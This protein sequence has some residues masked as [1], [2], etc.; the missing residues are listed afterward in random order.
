MYLQIG[1]GREKKYI[2]SD[3]SDEEEYRR[4]DLP[5]PSPRT[6]L[7]VMIGLNAFS[8]VPPPRS[9]GMHSDNRNLFNRSTSVKSLYDST[10]N[11]AGKFIQQWRARV[12][13]RR[14]SII[15]KLAGDCAIPANSTPRWIESS[16]LASVPELEQPVAL[17]ESRKSNWTL[18]HRP[19]LIKPAYLPGIGQRDDGERRE[20]FQA[21]VKDRKHELVPHDRP[22]SENL[23]PTQK[24]EHRRKSFMKFLKERRSSKSKHEENEEETIVPIFKD[25]Y[26]INDTQQDIGD[27]MNTILN[28]KKRFKDPLDFRVKKFYKELDQIKERDEKAQGPLTEKARKR[29]WKMLM[30]GID[31]A[32]ADSS[33]EEDNYLHTV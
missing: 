1:A 21:W 24:D 19:G 7:D 17:D 29:R 8:H 26:E 22:D 12:A 20:L 5:K 15:D 25:P 31:A 33:D 18:T 4:V 14:D 10:E 32:L 30:K 6:M 2:Q 16:F 11:I 27:M 3:D 13:S 28:I 9:P 23:N